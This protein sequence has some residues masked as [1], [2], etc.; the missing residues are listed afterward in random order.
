[1]WPLP[2][3]QHLLLVLNQVCPLKLEQLFN[4]CLLF[5]Q[6]EQYFYTLCVESGA[7]TGSLD[8]VFTVFSR[9]VEGLEVGIKLFRCSFTFATLSLSTAVKVVLF[10]L[11][12]KQSAKSRRVGKGTLW[13]CMNRWKID[14]R[15]SGSLLSNLDMWEPHFSSTPASRECSL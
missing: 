12:S 7:W 1:M 11:Y 2:Q 8:E 5:S 10:N 15:S 3:H 13:G 4:E 9:T 14:H 6:K